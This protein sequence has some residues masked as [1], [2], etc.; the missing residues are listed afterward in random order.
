MNE[1]ALFDLE[2]RLLL[3][4]LFQRYH[5]D[6]RDYALAS[7]RRRVRQAMQRLECES[8]AD[9]QN[10]VLHEP[11]AFAQ[12]LPFFTVQVSEMFRD[13]AYF[14][15]LREHVTPVLR[16]YPSLK[17]W[18]AGCS[19]GEEVWSLA[20]LL[21]EEGLLERTLIYATDINPQA[22]RAAESATYE[23]R[24][25]GGFS[26]NY[27]AAGGTGSLSDYYSSAYGRAVFDRRLRKHVVFADHSLATDAVFSEVHLVSCRNVLIYFNAGLQDRAI[28]LFREALVHRGF[29]GLGSRESL[30]SGANADAFEPLVAAQ[31]LFRKKA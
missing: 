2:V 5:H 14:L 15:A 25:V 6:F 17:I 1:E 30:R 20:I 22:L 4:A 8:V 27:Q 29:L 16:T 10:L 23:A 26:K 11:D 19:N 12:A 31:K 18:V 24:R 13:P 9:L 21:A 7:V 3:E 28:G